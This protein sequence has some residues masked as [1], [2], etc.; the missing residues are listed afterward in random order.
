MVLIFAKMVTR[1]QIVVLKPAPRD[2]NIEPYRRANKNQKSVKAELAQLGVGAGTGIQL[3]AS[4]FIILLCTAV[5]AVT[6]CL[7][8]K[9]V[10]GLPY[11]PYKKSDRATGGKPA[12][13]TT[14]PKTGTPNRGYYNPN[15][16]NLHPNTTKMTNNQR[17][18][19][20]YCPEAYYNYG[21][22]QQIGII[23]GVPLEFDIGKLE[24][25]NVHSVCRL[26]NKFGKPSTAIRLMFQVGA[27][28]QSTI[29]LENKNY[30]I[31]QFDE[32]RNKTG[33]IIS[34]PTYM[35][36]ENKSYIEAA[37][38]KTVAA[39]NSKFTPKPKL[40][41]VPQVEKLKSAP[42]I[43][44]TP[45]SFI[46]FVNAP[47]PLEQTVTKGEL[48]RVMMGFMLISVYAENAKQ[49]LEMMAQ[50]LQIELQLDDEDIEMTAEIMKS[51]PPPSNDI[52]Q[53]STPK[54]TRP[55]K[56][57]KND[58][59]KT[60]VS[61]IEHTEVPINISS[62]GTGSNSSDTTESDGDDSESSEEGETTPTKTNTS[63][64]VDYSFQKYIRNKYLTRGQC[65]I[66]NL[67]VN[68][69]GEVITS[70]SR[71]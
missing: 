10:G 28:F 41:K 3:N 33:K 70:S 20:H 39:K 38:P 4:G 18:A 9:T 32:K 7:K 57:D 2:K 14:G 16:T 12:V 61:H 67:S 37:K 58:T 43:P 48:S 27:I 55:T 60:D 31:G 63:A 47:H 65:K 5:S 51:C 23:K 19:G 66:L 59:D 8:L 54:C 49:K 40:P 46:N 17:T 45:D 29:K 62:E 22:K 11:A 25:G 1:P 15:P 44:A 71:T 6:Q 53:T 36:T 42:T 64:R 50:C 34:N 13:K 26:N 35:V 24:N 56:K 52:P 68:K 69:E 30:R 21:I